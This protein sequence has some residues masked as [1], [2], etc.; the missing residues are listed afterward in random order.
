MI[1]VWKD[2]VCEYDA[3]LKLARPKFMQEY[4]FQSWSGEIRLQQRFNSDRAFACTPALKAAKEVVENLWARTNGA[5]WESSMLMRDLALGLVDVLIVPFEQLHQQFENSFR[6]YMVRLPEYCS[7]STCQVEMTSPPGIHK[8]LRIE[9]TRANNY[10]PL[11]KW[12]RVVLD[13]AQN[14]SNAYSGVAQ[15]VAELS[16]VARWCVSGTPINNSLGDLHGLFRFLETGTSEALFGN[17]ATLQREVLGPFRNR[18]PTGLRRI[19]ALLA[20][21][22]WRH[23]KRHV[24]AEIE[25]SQD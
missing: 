11:R 16:A 3:Q 19:K 7:C 15:E 1:S 5:V 21:V 14:V 8:I 25:G 2:A 23:S 17:K 18:S 9:C 10:K 12:W 24:Q 13:E 4:Y 6:Y 20:S 22:M